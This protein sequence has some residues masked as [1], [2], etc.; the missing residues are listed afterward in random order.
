MAR[1]R[2]L[3]GVSA[4]VVLGSVGQAVL[5]PIVSRGAERRIADEAMFRYELETGKHVFAPTW[6]PRE[7]KVGQIG[8]RKGARR[9][10]LD[11]NDAESRPLLIVAQEARSP[12]R[13]QYHQRLFRDRADARARV[14]GANA[15]L[16]TGTSGERRLFWNEGDTAIILSSMILDDEELV[17]IGE[18]MR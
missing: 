8:F 6:L 12:E 16:I 18:R 2:W 17:K 9:L 14:R 11:Y 5:S 13:D 7:G 10:L 4:F 1:N 3:L 15:Y